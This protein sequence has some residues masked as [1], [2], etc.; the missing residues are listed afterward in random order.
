MDHRRWEYRD[1]MALL[2]RAALQLPAAEIRPVMDLARSKGGYVVDDIINTNA[3]GVLLGG[4]D[5]SALYLDVSRL[6]HACKPNMFSRF[7]SA[8]LAMEVVAY[9]D[10]AAGE[11]LTFSYTPLNLPSEPRQSLLREW[12]FNCT[13]ALCASARETAASDRRRARLQVLLE[14]L[15]QPRVRTRAGVGARVDEILALCDR[16]GLAAQVGDVYAIVADVYAAMGDLPLARR[17]GERAVAELT[18]Y[19]G[20]DHER[21]RNAV[22]FLAKL[23]AEAGAQVDRGGK[24]KVS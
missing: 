18:H 15:D 3:F 5:H 9:R 7:S 10:I 23:G 14:E 21:T 4:Q 17:Y 12:G 11:E 16:E 8:T 20:H 2:H 1:T 22:A 24:G 19:A 13:C 6:N